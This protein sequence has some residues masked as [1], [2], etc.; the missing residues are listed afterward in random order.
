MIPKFSVVVEQL[1]PPE[2]ADSRGKGT[3]ILPANEGEFVA[4]AGVRA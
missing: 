2:S 3:R 1:A 4:V